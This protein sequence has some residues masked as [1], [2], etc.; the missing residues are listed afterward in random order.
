MKYQMA[1]MGLSTLL[2]KD[3]LLRTNL[4]S[5]CRNVLFNLSI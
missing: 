3:K 1:P 4:D 2:E 5:R